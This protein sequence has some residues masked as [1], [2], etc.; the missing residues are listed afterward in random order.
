MSDLKG[1]RVVVTRAARQS[2]EFAAILNELGA[3][4]LF[5]PV[6]GIAPPLDSEP[7]RNAALALDSYD[8]VV[9]T[10]A[11][12]VDS[13]VAVLPDVSKRIRASIAAIGSATAKRAKECGLLVRLIPEVALSEGLVEAISEGDL[14]GKRILMPS[15]AVTRDVVATELRRRGAQV[16][17][18]ETYRNVLP[19]EAASA[20]EQVFSDPFPNWVTFAS[21][22]AVNN[23]VELVGVSSLSRCRLASIGPVTSEAL[24]AQGLRITIEASPHNTLAMAN[25]MASCNQTS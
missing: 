13:L 4:V 6:I 8:W 11:N 21:P 14:T 12:A 9:F 15:A 23:L 3:E 22:S 2:K 19:P 18:V 25:A 7:L 24:R 5:V 1:Q 20:A 16:D 17:V 10:S